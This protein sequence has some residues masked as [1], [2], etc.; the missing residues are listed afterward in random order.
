LEEELD[1]LLRHEIIKK[2]GDKYQTNIIIFTDVYEKEVANIIAPIYKKATERIKSLLI[3]AMPELRGLNFKGNDFNENRLKW[4]FANIALV[5]ALNLS[6][7]I[8]RERFGDYPPLTNGGYGF[9]FGYDNDYCNHHF[10]GIYGYC[11]NNDKNAYF[12]VV[13]YRVI[14]K[15]QRWQ[16]VIWDK[17]VEAMCD[18]ILE[19]APDENND[20]L[21]RLIDEGFI[22][23]SDNKLSAN[24]PVFSADLIDNTVRKVLKP[25]AEEAC[26]CMIQVCD[27]AAVTLKKYV[28]KALRE[29]CEQLC[30]IH[31]QM[32]V[33]A[34]IIEEMVAQGVLLIPEENEKLCIYGVKR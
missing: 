26:Q 10:N 22:S 16:P 25:I 6:D 12:T 14:E 30:Y 32:D 19:K 33:M 29:K 1:I 11:E 28:P 21:L 15:C 3:N 34:F 7:A 9:V 18:A 23:V 13:N 20:M 5:D 17:S 27:T 24:F 2:V 4:T 31:H 8:V